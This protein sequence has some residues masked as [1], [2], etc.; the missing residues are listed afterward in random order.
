MPLNTFTHDRSILQSPLEPSRLS[1]L[2][3]DTDAF[4]SYSSNPTDFI[5]NTLQ[6]AHNIGDMNNRRFT[7]QDSVSSSDMVDF[8]RFKIENGNIPIE[9][10]LTGLQADA[11]LSLLDSRGSLI[12]QS[13]NFGTISEFLN[14]PGLTAGTYYLKVSSFISTNTKYDLNLKVGGI[15]SDPGQ[16]LDTARDLGNLSRSSITTFD[17]V[18]LGMI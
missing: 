8:Y 5:G 15:V 13:S 18:G 10:T 14:N 17:T 6:T 1:L 2:S 16:S 4:I 12:S 3:Q 7:W 11:D 9:V